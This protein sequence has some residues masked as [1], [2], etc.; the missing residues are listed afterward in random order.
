MTGL[1]KAVVT[2]SVLLAVSLCGN[3]FLAGV[4]LSRPKGPP[5]MNEMSMGGRPGGI[6][7]REFVRELPPEVREQ[8]MAAFH[9]GSGEILQGMR[10]VMQSRRATIDALKAEPYDEAALLSALEA[11]RQAQLAVQAN[12]HTKLVS[13]ISQLEP[14]Q[15]AKLTQSARKLFK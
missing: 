6:N 4:V 8:V 12:V 10:G 5:P 3:A 15:R 2:L 1:Q 13:V 9:N 7:P 14:E 11:Q